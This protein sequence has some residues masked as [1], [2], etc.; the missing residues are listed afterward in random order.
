ML[1]R[2]A[3]NTNFI[4]FGLPQL[5][6]EPTSHHTNPTTVSILVW[7]KVDIIIISSIV[8][9]SCHDIAEKLLILPILTDYAN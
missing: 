5:L 2:E 8:T 7:Y 9:C 3:A 1:S 4:V 6:P